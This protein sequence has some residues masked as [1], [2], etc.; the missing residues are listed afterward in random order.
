MLGSGRFWDAAKNLAALDTAAEGLAWPVVVAGDLGDGEAPRHACAT[1][2]LDSRTLAALR[3]AAPIYA[4]PAVYEP[5]GLGILEAARDGCALVLGD[6]PSLRELWEDAAIFV[7]SH[8]P[9]ALREVLACL[10]DAPLLREDLATRAQ[11]RAGEYSIERTAAAYR[12]LYERLAAKVH[13]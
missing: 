9:E 7:D 2:V 1:G 4:A 8:D 11:E 10:I 12:Q 6:I 13:A 3:E 5:F